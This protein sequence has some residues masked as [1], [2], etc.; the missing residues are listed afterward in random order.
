MKKDSLKEVMDLMIEK[1]GT[2]I[3]I[4]WEGGND[5]GSYE[6]LAKDDRIAVRWHDR[7]TIE[8]RLIDML[9]DIIGYQSFAGEFNCNGSA[10]YDP[11]ENAF[12][13][14]DYYEESDSFK[15]KI[16]TGPIKIAVPKELWFDRVYVE[17]G[18]WGDEVNCT[19]RLE[20]SNGPVVGE[21]MSL[22]EQATMLIERTLEDT[23]LKEEWGDINSISFEES[24]EINA[25]PT[26]KDGNKIITIDSIDYS[27]Y[28]GKHIDIHIEIPNQ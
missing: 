16:P 10:T 23:L 17:I 19:F 12:I 24:F 21:H 18:G 5:E 25:L 11:D 20:I 4:T 2:D 6:L 15:Y 28:V 7:D 13:G 3:T 26:D 1:Y 27:K 8:Y 9:G 14:N 22:E